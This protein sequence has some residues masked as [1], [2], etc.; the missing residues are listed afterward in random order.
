MRCLGRLSVRSASHVEFCPYAVNCVADGVII[1][2]W[3]TGDRNCDGSINSLDIDPFV[4]ALTS[5][6][7]YRI[8]YP[9]CAHDLADTNRDGSINSLDI[10]PCVD[11]LTG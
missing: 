2:V 6:Y 5:E 9:G 11:L 3:L 8:L 10:D 1:Y 7:N 4:V